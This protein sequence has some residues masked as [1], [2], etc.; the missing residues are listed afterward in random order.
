MATTEAEYKNIIEYVQRQIAKWE[1]VYLTNEGYPDIRETCKYSDWK[2]QKGRVKK[3]KGGKWGK[4]FEEFWAAFPPKASFEYKGKKF[5][6]E[7]GK[8][9]N[10]QIAKQKYEDILD[11]G[12]ISHEAILKAMQVEVQT[13]KI[14]S[15]KQGKNVLHYMN[16]IIPY[17]N[18]RKYEVYLG[19]DFP[20]EE[21][22]QT[23]TIIS[24]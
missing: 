16:G 6:S 1:G 10:Y 9:S 8:R 3:D 23:N 20:E 15:Y 14:E 12:K 18:G 19:E 5:T 22:K 11:E 13:R 21:N 2:E 17:L 7:Q 4:Q 24:I